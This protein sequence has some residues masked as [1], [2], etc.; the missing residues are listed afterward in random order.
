MHHRPEEGVVL[1]ERLVLLFAHV[2]PLVA[3]VVP[4]QNRHAERERRDA[5]S[6]E[7]IDVMMS[8]PDVTWGLT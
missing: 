5:D 8:A 6:C 1:G 2:G 4:V 3:L 7:N